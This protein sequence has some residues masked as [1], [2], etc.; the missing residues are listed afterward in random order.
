M[1]DFTEQDQRITREFNRYRLAPPSPDLHDRVLL[2]AREAM[3]NGAAELHW[4]N[5]WRRACWAFQQE[6]LAFASVLMLITGVV[7]QLGGGQSV[8]ADSMERLAVMAAVSGS[9]YRATS[10]DCAVLK[11][12]AGEETTDYRIRWNASGVTRID[13]D[14]AKDTKRMMWISKETA[15]VA[16]H[17][18][19]VRSMA[20]SALPPEWQPP[21]EFLTPS[22][23]AQRMEGYGLTQAERQSD[24]QPGELRFVGQEDQQAIEMSVDAKTGLPIKLKKYLP[25]SSRTGKKR[26][27]MEE[28]RF[29]WNRPIPQELFVPD[30]PEVKQQVH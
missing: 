8:L 4:T 19:E 22:I 28:V 2:A 23:L 14:S 18:G 7:M 3:A 5:R 21:T 13:M 29:Q 10:M 1:K 20:I 16:N 11:R 15:S 24:A 25:D 30:S 27:C 17:K 12:D 26:D 9:V 6:I